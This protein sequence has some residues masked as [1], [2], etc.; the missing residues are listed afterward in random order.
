MS[1]KDELNFDHSEPKADS[2]DMSEI[3]QEINTDQDIDEAASVH[4]DRVENQEEVTEAFNTTAI[5][6][7]D[8]APEQSELIADR[9]VETETAADEALYEEAEEVEPLVPE[10]E[11][12]YG[13]ELPRDEDMA[14]PKPK[15]NRVGALVLSALAFGV[16]A[17]STMVGV[18]M[19]SNTYF[20]PNESQTMEETTEQPQTEAD[21]AVTKPEDKV[22][23]APIELTT[24]ADIPSMVEKVMPSVVAINNTMVY[25]DDSWFGQGQTYEVPSSGSGII[26]G[27][28]EEELLII[29]NNHVVEGS[30]NLQVNFIDNA[31]VDAAIKGTDPVFDLAVIAVRLEDIPEDTRSQIDIATLGD[32]DAVSVG[33]TVVAIGNAL[34]YGQSV[35]VGV[36]S[37]LDREIQTERDTISNLMQTD[38][39]INPGNSGGALL[40]MNGEVI[41]IN[42]AKYA[43]EQVEGMGYAIPITKVQD[44]ISQLMS[45]KTRTEID[46]ENR[47]Y[48]GIRGRDITDVYA[49][50]LGMPKGIYVSEIIADGAAAESDLRERDIITKFDDQSVRTM[51]D[52][53]QILSYYEGG[54]TINLTVQSQEN[55]QY[56]ERTVEITLGFRPA[57]E[58]Q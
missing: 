54:D 25:R 49:E 3:S 7:A 19:V 21:L 52:L 34:G 22:T 41:G 37:A 56:V 9:L 58:Q 33:E 17:G 20:V 26:V 14:A 5:E 40:N 44:I 51:A 24:G 46:E 15:K 36:I 16:I 18:Q 4:V 35:T 13:Y 6:A 32:S 30:S 10:P 8:E 53:Q 23:A 12:S 2:S 57:E 42:A 50:E 47:G 38:A 27:E 45:K 11:S 31:S 48:L 55:G 28:N 29:T 43:S 39:A 1:N